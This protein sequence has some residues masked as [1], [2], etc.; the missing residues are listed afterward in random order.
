MLLKYEHGMENKYF[1]KPMDI[2]LTPHFFQIF[3]Y[4]FIFGNASSSLKE[5]NSM[6]ISEQIAKKIFGNGNP[7]NKTLTIGLPYGDFNYTS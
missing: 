2:M 4:D 3:S 7:L 6:V 1:M 5:P